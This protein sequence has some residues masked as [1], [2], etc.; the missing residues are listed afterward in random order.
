MRAA[1][2]AAC[3]S[4]R[5]PCTADAAITASVK[6]LVG[7]SLVHP[8]AGGGR[9]SQRPA[10]PVAPAPGAG[11]AAG[12]PQLQPR[13]GTLQVGATEQCTGCLCLARQGLVPD[14]ALGQVAA[15]LT[16][17]DLAVTGSQPR[18]VHDTQACALERMRAVHCKQA[19]THPASFPPPS[20][21]PALLCAA[22]T[23]RRCWPAPPPAPL[24]ST[25]CN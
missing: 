23:R 13:P 25:W 2:D 22:S 21:F 15:C 20:P 10:V 8:T 1:G 19:A 4:P 5:L 17:A 7:R 12:G 3:G 18:T 11:Q 14:K 6:L 9:S 24:G 16:F